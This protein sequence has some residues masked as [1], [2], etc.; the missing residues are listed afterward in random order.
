MGSAASASHPLGPESHAKSP[1]SHPVDQ[2]WEL[3]LVNGPQQHKNQLRH[4]ASPNGCGNVASNPSSGAHKMSEAVFD[5]RGF[6]E[7]LAVGNDG[8]WVH[9]NRADARPIPASDAFRVGAAHGYK[10]RFSNGVQKDSPGNDPWRAQ[11]NH[12]P[13]FV[14]ANIHPG[15][16]GGQWMWCDAEFGG[17]GRLRMGKI[18]G[19]KGACFADE[20]GGF[21]WKWYGRN[22]SRAA[23][24]STR[25]SSPR[26][27]PSHRRSHKGDAMTS[28][29]AFLGKTLESYPVGKPQQVVETFWFE[30]R[31]DGTWATIGSKSGRNEYWMKNNSLVHKVH[32]GVHARLEGGEFKWSHGFCSRLMESEQSSSTPATDASTA[33]VALDESFRLAAMNSAATVSRPDAAEA[34]WELNMSGQPFKGKWTP[35]SEDWSIA[36]EAAFQAML[37]GGDP[38]IDAMVDSGGTIDFNSFALTRHDR[39]ADRPMRRVEAGKVTHPA[40]DVPHPWY[41]EKVRKVETRGGSGDWLTNAFFFH[42]FQQA[43]QRDG[44]KLGFLAPEMFSFQFCNDFRQAKPNLERRGGVLYQ[45]PAGWK[46]FALNV[47]DKYPDGNDWMRMDGSP[48]EWAVAYHGTKFDAVPKIIQNGFRLGI[49]HG[50]AAMKLKDTQTGEQI[51]EGICCTPNLQVVECFAN[52]EEADTGRPPVTLDGHTLFFALQCRVRPGAIRRPNNTTYTKTNNDEEQMGVHGVFEWVIENPVDIR[53][54]AVLVRDRQSCPNKKSLH[55]LAQSF[56]SMKAKPGAFEHIPGHIEKEAQAAAEQLQ[57]NQMDRRAI[58]RLSGEEA[59]K[60]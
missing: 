12:G 55:E 45:V 56:A 34:Y 49:R 19:T 5:A 44:G 23:S 16:E 20:N 59:R 42:A 38:C 40:A 33:I 47:K 3:Y 51:G 7:V 53:P 13:F 27:Q 11:G 2:G 30:N 9:V 4:G 26:E 10:L 35:F 52:G 25:A 54:Y 32:H 24:P 39:N 60:G 17:P 37:A 31:A 36:I 46:R 28:W 18:L 1:I 14:D 8:S 43:V 50:P 21:V 41:M 15:Q 22:G 57:M 29:E 6:T 58:P 48:G